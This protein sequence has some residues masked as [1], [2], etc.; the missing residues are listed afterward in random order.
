MARW[1]VILAGGR[2][3]RFWPLSRVMHPKQ[4][5][6][7]VGDKSM[8]ESTRERVSALIDEA[9]TYVVTGSDYVDKVSANL[10]GVPMNQ[11]LGEPRGC[12]TA[13]SITWAATSIFRRDPDAV[14]LV[15]PSDHVIQKP[16][17]F[18][19][20]A[21][22]ALTLAAQHGGFFTFGIVPTHPETGYGYIERDGTA[23]GDGQTL[24]VRRFVEKPPR[25]VAEAMV[26]SG[27][28]FWNSGMFAFR[29]TDLLD[30]VREFLP[31]LADGIATLVD[32]PD[33]IEEIFEKLP[34]IS[35]DHGVMENARSVYVLPAD[36]GWDDVG[37]FGALAKLLPRN[38]EKNAANGYAIF[39]ESENVTA[40]SDGPLI[41]FVG[42]KDLYVVATH[43]AVLILS[44][45][46][47]QDVRKV[48]QALKAGGSHEHLL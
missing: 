1:L 6:T 39:V 5:L 4:F 2:G 34:A 11:I 35:I 26:A 8:L 18:L 10:P 22:R 48:V 37:T 27:R 25:D 42:V 47:S 29:V 21:D 23:F 43:D 30:A 33:R 32:S 16:Q 38:G 7:L 14:I 36:I 19:H 41:S 24:E 17:D 46:R 28:Y 45:D 31:D 15:L 13:P 40:I 9:H 12:N 20:L 44:P 3:E